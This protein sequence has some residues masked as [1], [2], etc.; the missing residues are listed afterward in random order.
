MAGDEMG[1][2]RCC[3]WEE[4]YSDV[5][6]DEYTVQ[7]NERHKEFERVG[8]LK[9]KKEF[10]SDPNDIVI[11]ECNV[12]VYLDEKY[13]MT[14]GTG[15]AA[16]IRFS[17]LVDKGILDAL[18][19]ERAFACNREVYITGKSLMNFIAKEYPEKMVQANEY[20]TDF[21][22]IYKISCYDIS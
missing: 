2:G 15:V 18:R 6:Q 11:T 19:T 12:G 5:F 3:A 10:I 8:K 1:T 13:I 17:D 9:A 14:F 4:Y 22:A 21:D 20:I 7:Y 16:V